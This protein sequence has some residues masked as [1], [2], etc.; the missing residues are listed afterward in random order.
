MIGA[1]PRIMNPLVSILEKFRDT[2][3]LVIG[4]LML[5]RFI[6][7]EVERLSPEAPVPVLRV[8]S[9][10]SSL[11]GAANVIHNVR[12]LGGRVTAC[13]VVGRDD[14]GKRIMAAL[15]KVDASTA[16]VF[17]DAKFQTIQKSRIVASPRHQ[18]IV[19]LDRE[20]R[21]PIGESTLKKLRQFV[22][23]CAA[24]FD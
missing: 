2:H 8:V 5:D 11:G 17:S 3:L 18:Q 16:G 14:A 10:S 7:G 22:L 24:R 9:E 1:S 13:G 23:R 21:E 15:R 6:W 20:G 4:D 19:R 12:A